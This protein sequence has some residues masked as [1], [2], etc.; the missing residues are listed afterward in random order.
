MK[1]QNYSN[2]AR[3]VPVFHFFI[4]PAAFILFI[5][6]IVNLVKS[7]EDNMYNASLLVLGSFLLLMI[8]L[9]GR[10]FALKAQDRAIY[11]E[12]QFRYFVLTNKLLPKNLSIR[13]VIGLRFAS[14]E[15]FPALVERAISE[16]LSEKEIKKAIKK[17]RAD[18]YRV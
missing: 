7:S 10:G 9:F 14:D 13:Q 16:K 11:A 2:H 12:E 4:M 6:T 17:W 3:F 18:H 15:E 5:G 1:E 8:A